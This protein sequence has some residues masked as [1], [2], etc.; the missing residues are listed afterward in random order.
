MNIK[1]PAFK[2]GFSNLAL[3]TGIALAINWLNGKSNIKILVV[4]TTKMTTFY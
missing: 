3:L 2:A 4:K 1:K